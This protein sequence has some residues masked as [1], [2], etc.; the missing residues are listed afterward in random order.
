MVTVFLVLF[1]VV[2]LLL[3]DR[4]PMELI[5]LLALL[6]LTFLGAID[7]DEATEGF[8]DGVVITMGGLFV[9]GGAL[10][11]TGVAQMAG[12][13]LQRWSRG[14][15]TRLLCLVVLVAACLSTVLSST[16]TVALLIP[17]VV[18]AAQVAG[19]S[20]SK[21]L[22]P[23]AYGSLL[24]GMFTVIGSTPNLIVNEALKGLGRPGFGF[25][26]FAWIGAPIFACALFYLLLAGTRLL[27]ERVAPDE[28]TR[29]PT[30]EDLLSEYQVMDDLFEIDL[31]PEGRW[32]CTSLGELRLRSEYHIDVLAI[33][34]VGTGAVLYPSVSGRLTAGSVLYARA[35]VSDLKR[36]GERFGATFRPYHSAP[37]PPSLGD[38]GL[39]EVI[40]VPRSRL[41][42]KSLAESRFFSRFGVRVIRVR[43]AGRIVSGDVAETRLKFG[44]ALLVEGPGSKLSELER[45][46]FDFVVVSALSNA[47]PGRLTSK[48]KWT[49][50]I[51]ATM[52][53]A[54]TLGWLTPALATVA[55]AVVAILSGC[56]TVEEAYSSVHWGS[57]I[58]VA[59]MLPLGTA[60]SN[61][62]G[63]DFL[64]ARLVD[65]A[66]HLGPHAVLL[67]IY[68]VTTLLGQVMS[69]TATALILTPLAIKAA[70][71]LQV[72][73]E[74]LLMGVAFGASTAFLTPIASPVNTLVVAPGNYQFLDFLKVGLPLHLMAST[75][76][77]LVIPLA[78]PFALKA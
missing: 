67:G 41:D 30:V 75:I 48:G 20:P 10:I 65:T 37:A 32:Q 28:A 43:R 13:L 69:N 49:L 26:S 17:A 58:L 64:T 72:A 73:P 50:V 39:A 7:H 34:E 11:K 15:H 1:A 40:L 23:L 19:R 77:V 53:L 52:L 36:F 78:F 24:G 38:L 29:P 5:G 3:L 63:I 14:C 33:R 44:D 18:G 76:C 4:I 74:P 66:G 57:L 16:G 70:Q 25:F 9:V 68:L 60:L 46:R 55:A 6:A 59:S 31:P 45:E 8:G 47:D 51:T 21:Y 35:E 2:A 62:G 27:P 56:L 71:L 42:G 54:I 22:I 61:S 12:S